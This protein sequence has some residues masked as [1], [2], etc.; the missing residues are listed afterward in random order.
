MKYE[1]M[2][3]KAYGELP[4]VL[5]VHARFETPVV[6]SIIQGSTTVVTN[7]SSLSKDANREADLIAKYLIK[8]MGTA[9]THDEQRLTLKG[10]FKAPQVQEKFEAFLKQYV[11]CPDCSRPDTKIIKEGRMH[12]LRCEACGAKHPITLAKAA[13]KVEQ[14][15]PGV[16]DLLTAE[17][18]G[19]GKKGDGTA[20]MGR[21]IVFIPGAKVGQTINIKVTGKQG[22]MLFAEMVKAAK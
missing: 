1:E 9:G 10:Q 17:I 4:E 16:G 2:L 22:T 14:K 6:E 20:K 5:K 18:T 21:Y 11:L 15:E 19:M 3:E 13:P 12:F 7:L 8:E